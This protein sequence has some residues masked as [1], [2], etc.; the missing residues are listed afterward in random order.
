M[1]KFSVG[2]IAVFTSGMFAGQECEIVKIGYE[3]IMGTKKDYAV[4]CSEKSLAVG[5]LWGC[6]ESSLR[7]KY[8]GH[9][10]SRWDEIKDDQGLVIWSPPREIA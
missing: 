3:T 4:N 6:L 7:K 2:E 5:G 8:D 9:T 1:S 10:K